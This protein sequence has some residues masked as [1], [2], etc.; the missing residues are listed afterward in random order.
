MNMKISEDDQ[1]TYFSSLTEFVGLT[2]GTVPYK[3]SHLD[4]SMDALRLSEVTYGVDTFCVA[5]EGLVS[6]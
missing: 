4:T 3:F 1:N 5:F 6:T 2:A